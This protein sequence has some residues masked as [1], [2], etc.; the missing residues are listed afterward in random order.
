MI[1]IVVTF[2]KYSTLILFG[3]PLLSDL[4]FQIK[5][6]NVSISISPYYYDCQLWGL[7]INNCD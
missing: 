1:G 5:S 2:Q 7:Y 3:E 6:V 4:I